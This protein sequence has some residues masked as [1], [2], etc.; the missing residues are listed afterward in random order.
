MRI[1]FDA[2]PLQSSITRYQGIGYYTSGLLRGIERLD[3][4][5]DYVFCIET[6][7]PLEWL[8]SIG[9][10]SEV[11]R[12]WIPRLSPCLVEVWNQIAV[13]W[14]I[15]RSRVDVFHAARVETVAWWMPAPTVVTLYDMLTYVYADQLLHTGLKYRLLHRFASR[16]TAIIAIS[17]N[18]KA[19]ICRFL[20]VPSERVVVIPG[21][22]DERFK[23]VSDPVQLDA[24][25]SRY[26]LDGPFVLYV[27]DLRSELHNTR[28]NLARLV[29]S[30]AELIRTYD[31]PIQLVLAGKT[32]NY[33]ERLRQQ[34][35]ALGLTSRVVFTDFVS[36]AD[37]PALYSAAELFVYPSVHEGFGLP[38]L[39]AMACGAPVVCS[40]ATSLPEVAGEAA[41]LVEVRDTRALA[42]AMRRLLM[43]PGL[44][45]HMIRL[46]FRQASQFT[47]ERAARATLDLY[48]RVATS[49]PS[50]T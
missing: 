22:V 47:W 40:N 35:F 34:I 46:G 16:C 38:V 33:A 45:E 9:R 19:E 10:S 48:H 4:I 50:R 23:P 1:G 13:P 32:G 12:V 27:G 7:Q 8:P 6:G 20:N 49:S 30:F 37:L 24:I 3:Q 18:T 17:E 39:E 14:Q 41:L 11:N 43:E 42:E 44:R 21:G 31:R 36:D 25:R 2:R 5:N 28:K 15:A 26:G 29:D